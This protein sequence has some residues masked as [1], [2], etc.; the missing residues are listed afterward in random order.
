MPTGAPAPG[1]QPPDAPTMVTRMP[2]GADQPTEQAG[3]RRTRTVVIAVVALIVLAALVVAAV[4]Y[5]G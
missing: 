3:S 1:A 5:L 4:I 2:G